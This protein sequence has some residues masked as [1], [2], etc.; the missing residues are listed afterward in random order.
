MLDGRVGPGGETLYVRLSR[1]PAVIQI[2]CG[3]GYMVYGVGGMEKSGGGGE[4]EVW[5][6]DEW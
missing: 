5:L 4:G 6:E 3:G 1:P 2:R